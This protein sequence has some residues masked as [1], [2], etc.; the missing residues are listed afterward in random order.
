MN[1]KI[2]TGL[3]ILVLLVLAVLGNQFGLYSVIVGGESCDAVFECVDADLC[4]ELFTTSD[5][6]VEITEAGNLLACVQQEVQVGRGYE[7]ATIIEDVE[8]NQYYDMVINE[9][10]SD[11]PSEEDSSLTWV[12]LEVDVS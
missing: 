7:T 5:S 12:R 9:I 6:C 1:K 8:L 10:D 3:G 2:V 4:C 11:Y